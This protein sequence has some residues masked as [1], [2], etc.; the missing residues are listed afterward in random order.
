MDMHL[1]DLTNFNQHDF[2]IHYTFNDDNLHDI[3]VNTFANSLIQFSEVIKLVSK[4]TLPDYIIEITIDRTGEGT[5]WGHFKMKGKNFLTQVKEFL[6]TKDNTMAVTIAVL[7]LLKTCDKE[8]KPIIQNNYVIINNNIKIDVTTYDK[9]YKLSQKPEIQTVAKK[10]FDALTEDNSISAFSIAKNPE[11]CKKH[12][13]IISVDR[14]EFENFEV[15]VEEDIK[16]DI[17]LKQILHPIKVILEKS[18]RKWEFIWDGRR[19]SA[20]VSCDKF[21]KD[22]SEGKIGFKPK[23]YIIA[24][25]R[26]KQRLDKVNNVF[27]NEDYEI[28]EIEEY[29]FY[30]EKQEKLSLN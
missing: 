5:F 3:N 18:K 22:S 12:N 25:L 6:P 30:A 7:S 17:R 15:G 16:Y 14:Q 28:T 27:I 20:N 24:N 13:F 2:C 29:I 26:I 8:A 9:A 11:D 21:Y 19:I 10:T 23:D 4:E 1:I